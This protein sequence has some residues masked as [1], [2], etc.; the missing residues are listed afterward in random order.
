MNAR[1]LL[2]PAGSGK[3]HRCLSEIREQLLASPDGPPLLLLAPKQ[4]TFQLER[5]ILLDERISG[6]TRLQ[7][8]SFE[9]LASHLLELSGTSPLPLLSEE[10]R[11]MV[12]RALIAQH[13]D[14]LKIFGASAFMGGFSRQLSKDLRELQHH[15]LS[16]KKLIET[17][18]RL[19]S[20]LREK[21][22]DLQFLLSAYLEWMEKQHLQDADCLLDAAADVLKKNPL[23]DFSTCEEGSPTVV[24]SGQLDLFA[25]PPALPVR[26]KFKPSVLFSSLWMDGFAEMTP[27]ELSL[28]TALA[29]H[30]ENMTLAFCENPSEE[31]ANKA[32]SWLSIWSGINQTRTECQARLSALSDVNITVEVLEGRPRFFNNPVLGHLERHWTKS[33]P[34]NETDLSR[35]LRLA[36]CASPSNEAV[37]AAHEILRFVRAGGRYREAAVLLRQMDGY[38]DELRRVFASCQIPCF[39]DRRESVA[40]HPLAELT[41]C[42]LST[43]AFNWTH[44]DW[45]GALKT[46][47]VSSDENAV[48]ELENAALAHGWKG[49]SWFKPLLCD[50][51]PASWAERSTTQWLPPFVKLKESLT[52]DGKLQADGQQLANALRTFWHDLHVEKTLD[53]WQQAAISG[54]PTPHKTV[55]EQLNKWLDDIERAFLK[56][57]LPLNQWLPILEASLGSLTVGVIPPA[58]DQVLIGTIDRSRN[59]DLKLALILGVNESVFPCVPEAVAL[60]TDTDRTALEKQGIQLGPTLRQF[61]SREHFLGYIAFTRSNDRL[62]VTYSKHDAQDRTLNPSPFISHIRTLFPTLKLEEIFS[63]T[64]AWNEAEHESE[65]VA[66]LLQAKEGR[67]PTLTPWLNHPKLASILKNL[68]LLSV[69]PVTLSPRAVNSLYTRTLSTSVSRLEEFAECPF[70][71][72]VDAGL[73]AKERI[74]FELDPRKKGDFQHTVLA[75]FHQKIQSQKKRWHDLSPAQAR[76]L[77]AQI[78]AELAPDFSEGL[79]ATG[80]QSKVVVKSMTRGLQDFLATVIFW[81]DQYEFE[82]EAVE[83]VFGTKDGLLPAWKLD[84][85]NEHEMM[86]CGAMDRV[87]LLRSE[88]GKSAS[89]VII[90]YKS[91]DHKLETLRMANGL[92]LQLPAY[93]AVLRYHPGSATFFGVEHLTPVGAF[94]ANFRGSS[95]GGKTRRDVLDTTEQQSQKAFQHTGRFDFTALPHL[96]NRKEMCGT[97]FKF[98]IKKDGTSSSTSPDPMTQEKFNELISNVKEILLRM[99][100]QIFSGTS[101]PA[102][103]QKGSERACDLCEFQGICRI[104]PWTHTFRSLTSTANEDVST[105]DN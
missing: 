35:H 70:K 24:S 32:S 62:V 64:T 55:W 40:H 67:A 58:L 92:Q 74:L 44:E 27:Q 8:L 82:P 61:L 42:A 93:L 34:C 60:L 88:D 18:D 19:E 54:V 33:E 98:R 103:Y 21:L 36:V 49:Q 76:E 29:P 6:Y 56:E 90:D 3:T 72:F 53:G 2:G 26:K 14:K 30:C 48:D 39:L 41:R 50:H 12:L 25:P 15:Q 16:P 46:G 23:P 13:S 57:I 10:G 97:Q 84:L 5:Q 4:A 66:P 38:H 87:D 71:Y 63:T 102:P 7:I 105:T 79:L 43:V 77:V 99:G 85:G 73:N 52:T 100:Q 94:Y 83:L 65:L 22:L 17:A 96:D 47:L 69:Q 91:S 28:L 20:P 81:M 59:P 89:A 1:F 9:R 51:Q 104:D 86:F 11:I 31:N 37:L 45:F 101:E 95:S 68:N 80:E 75:R 78:A